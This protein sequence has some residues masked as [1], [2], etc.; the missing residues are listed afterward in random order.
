MRNRLAVLGDFKSRKHNSIDYLLKNM[1]DYRIGKT[2][3]RVND[4]NYI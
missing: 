1:L 2:T 3:Q 4:P